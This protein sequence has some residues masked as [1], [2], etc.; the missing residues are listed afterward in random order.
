MFVQQQ[1]IS[2]SAPESTLLQ[3]TEED[4][5][6]RAYRKSN[7]LKFRWVFQTANGRVK[8]KLFSLSPEKFDAE[9]VAKTLD[10]QLR[11][12][13]KSELG[14]VSEAHLVLYLAG[15][16]QPMNYG[17]AVLI[18]NIQAELIP[19]DSDI[20]EIRGL[21]RG[22]L[23]IVLYPEGGEVCFS[24]EVFDHAGFDPSSGRN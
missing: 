21:K 13:L 17:L 2:K 23:G 24:R 18:R 4:R 11:T 15:E 6:S 5:R 22:K 12:G 10:S 9:N 19:A 3:L 7:F 16:T 14:P 1:V 20:T 8:S